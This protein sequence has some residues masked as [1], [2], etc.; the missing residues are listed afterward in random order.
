MTESV[1]PLSIRPAAQADEPFLRAMSELTGNWRPDAPPRA[2]EELAADP[3]HA[4]YMDGWVREGDAGVIAERDGRPVGAAWYRTFSPDA[5]GY[6][7]IDASTPEVSIAVQRDE[8]GQGVGT[9]LLRALCERAR[10]DG[11]AAL[12]LSVEFDNPAL[13]LYRRVGFVEVERS[14]DACTMR[15]DLQEG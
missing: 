15:I 8:R 11:L 13:R 3:H 12:S 14:P 6:G 7:F 10:E 1:A 4:R 9:A 5:P 2:S